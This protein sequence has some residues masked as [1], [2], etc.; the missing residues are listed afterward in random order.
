MNEYFLHP[1]VF[2]L[3]VLFAI[4]LLFRAAP[5][6]RVQCSAVIVC[7]TLVIYLST[8]LVTGWDT[9]IASLQVLGILLGTVLSIA[10]VWLTLRLTDWFTIRQLEAD[11][12]G[13][14]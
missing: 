12:R 11:I 4:G 5:K 8:N 13:P 2:T 9:H 3:L 10:M 14:N 7:A 6:E 1:F